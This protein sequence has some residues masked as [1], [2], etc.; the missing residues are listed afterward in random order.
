MPNATLPRILKSQGIGPFAIE[1]AGPDGDFFA[2]IDLAG[3][4][5]LTAGGNCRQVG[6]M[7]AAALGAESYEAALTAVAAWAPVIFTEHGRAYRPRS[8]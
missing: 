3:L 7:E 1:L 2:L 8:N 6:E 4:A 5:M